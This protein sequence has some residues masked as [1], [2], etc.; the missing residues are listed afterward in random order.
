MEQVLLIIAQQATLH[1]VDRTVWAET[2]SAHLNQI[3]AKTVEEVL[4]L[5]L[6]LRP[7]EGVFRRQEEVLRHHPEVVLHR[8]HQEVALRRPEEVLRRRS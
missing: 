8:R 5:P 6:H 3:T 1:V 7:P 4:R 2:K